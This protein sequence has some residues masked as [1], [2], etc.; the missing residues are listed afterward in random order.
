MSQSISKLSSTSFPLVL[1]MA[2][3]SAFAEP[4]GLSEGE[5]HLNALSAQGIEA[6]AVLSIDGRGIPLVCGTVSS[7]QKMKLTGDAAAR[8]PP[9]PAA[10][11]PV[12]TRMWEA[13]PGVVRND[14]S[15][16]FRIEVNANGPVSNVTMQIW[17]AVIAD[18]GQTNVTLR[19]DGL[20]GDQKAGDFV[21]TSEWLRF[22][23]N[24]PWSFDP[25]YRFDT[26][27]PSGVSIEDVG[28]VT[29]T[30]T[31]GAQTGF[32]VFPVIGVLRSD[33]PLVETVM[34][35][36]NVVISPHL[37][38]VRGTNLSTQ[39]FLR[40]F[41]VGMADLSRLLYGVFPDAF[42]FLIHFSTYHLE[43]VPYDDGRN[44]N[45]GSQW[46]V[47][48]NFTGTGQAPFNNSATY[49]SAGRLLGVIALDSYDRGMLSYNCTHEILHQWGSFL[50]GLPISDGQHYVSRSSVASLL[51]GQ[52]W[53]TNGDG[54]WTLVCEEGRNGATHLDPLD[55][56]LMGLIH[57]S[58][59]P[60]LHVYPSTN[61]PPLFICGSTISNVQ[62]TVTI[63]N[64]L[65]AYGPRSPDPVTAQRAFSIGFVV[66][67]HDRLLNPVEMTF[68]DIFAGHFTR[69]VP[70]GQPDPYV[71]FNWT[72]ITRFFGEGTTWSSEVLS[73]IRPTI[74]R[75]ENLPGG[76]PRITARGYPGRSYRLLRSTNGFV[77]WIAVTNR[78][79]DANGL[80]LLA[81]PLAAVS[82]ARFYRVA[83]P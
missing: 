1:T 58:A 79:A 2:A 35:S 18:S 27:S 38:N 76:N 17:P 63:G 67:T 73:L 11:L 54:T 51:G 56:Y 53:A 50:G 82:A 78:S 83:T 14:G 19:D 80:C 6:G 41:N 61:P 74:L 13:V 29:I 9:S 40:I 4:S 15:D 24:Q 66:E 46:P 28:P 21:F 47:Q 34:L 72:P 25:Y 44:F 60:P 32:L 39:K 5:F 7:E 31:N 8:S 12:G 20:Q 36:S 43:R 48:V 52:L 30:Q 62:N 49:G 77:N 71:G 37:V 42:D 10:A 22:N 23:T 3:L 45:S 68:Y 16:A 75:I 69:P 70:D 57:S 55:K 59:V 81:D 33:L 64:I 65:A 26:N